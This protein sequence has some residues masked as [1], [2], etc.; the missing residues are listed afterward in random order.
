MGF[1]EEM[2]GSVPTG[3]G[4][5]SAPGEKKQYVLRIQE[6]FL[7]HIM[8]ERKTV[9]G[10]IAKSG[11]LNVFPGEILRFECG[12]QHVDVKVLAMVKYMS[13]KEMLE[14]EGLMNCLPDCADIDS[15][16]AA[17]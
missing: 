11:M 4:A 5:D 10:R 3:M 17:Q 7:W 6:E 2:A 9:E 13:F 14:N 8:Q 12:C 16:V 1:V 15:G